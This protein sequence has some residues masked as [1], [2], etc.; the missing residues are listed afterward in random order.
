[1]GLL[2]DIV[3]EKEREIARLRA[4]PLPA[5]T[6]RRVD[7]DPYEALRRPASGK[8]R[9]LAEIKR[10]SPSAG[11]LS[12]AMSV[13]DRGLAYERA[14]A[15]AISVLSDGPFFGGSFDDLAAVSARVSVPTLCKDFVLD[16][17]Q[18]AHARASGASLVLLIVRLLDQPA[19][20]R[21][22]DAARAYDLAPLV[23]ITNEEELE[24]ALAVGARVIGVNARDL[25]TLVMDAARAARVLALIPRGRVAIHLSG[26]K[27]PDDVRAIAAGRAD[28][29]L[30]GEALMRADDPEPLLRRLI[31]AC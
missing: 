26:L 28:A 19:L 21:L 10:R 23:E 11:A 15:V 1:M 16:E 20:A 9:L 12:A 17:V 18:L 29:A 13:V 7:V 6:K 4:A 2:D 31:E 30:T 24:R 27:T 25:D 3:T 8:L 22:V 5:P 14:G